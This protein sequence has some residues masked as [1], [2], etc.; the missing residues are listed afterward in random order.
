MIVPFGANNFADTPRMGA[1]V[2]HTLKNVL[3]KKGIQLLWEMREDL[4]RTITFL[5]TS[6]LKS[7]FLPGMPLVYE[8][9]DDLKPIRNYYLGDSEKVRKAMEAVA[10][11]AKAGTSLLMLQG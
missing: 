7:T 5:T 1:E 11:Q 3:K 6:S 2:F 10:A 8:L 4:L 9:E